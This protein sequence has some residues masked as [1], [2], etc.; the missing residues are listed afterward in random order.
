MNFKELARN[1]EMGEEEFLEIVDLF[2]ETT[3]SD[4]GKLQSAVEERDAQGVA[5]TAHSIKGAAAIL[6]LA[7]IY[8][9][10]KRIE[11]DAREN[12]LERTNGAVKTIKEKI[13]LIAE[14]LFKGRIDDKGTSPN[15][16]F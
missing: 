4:L 6:T 9:A 2:F 14:A 5:E 1:L 13:D 15:P 3:S 12:H 16:K 11:M 7:E 10:A 8:E